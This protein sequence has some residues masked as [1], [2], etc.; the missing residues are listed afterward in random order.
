M[1]ASSSSRK[2]SPESIVF[3]QPSPLDSEVSRIFRAPPE[4]VFRL[5]TDPATIPYLFA[6]DPESVTI[7][8]LDFRV[9]GRYS[10]AARMDD[11]TIVRFKGEYREIEPPRRVVN[12]FE[13]DMFPG[14]SAIETDEF[15]PIGEFTRLTV[16]WKYT[17]QED[18]D[19]MV[20]P[21]M[22]AAVTQMWNNVAKLLEKGSPELAESRV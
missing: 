12:T 21:Q 5:F 14:A 16:R 22:E 18:R 9:G 4:R 15:E 19:K 1:A 13:V 10:I 7:E 8:R 11:G 17:R 20:G 2:R 3:S 6:P